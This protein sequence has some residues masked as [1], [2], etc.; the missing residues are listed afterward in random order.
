MGLSLLS[1]R[2]STDER[3]IFTVCLSAAAHKFLATVL[4]SEEHDDELTEHLQ[5]RLLH[6]KRA[7]LA[8]LNRIRLVTSPSLS[9]LQ[10]IL[11]GVGL[12]ICYLPTLTS[13]Q[14]DLAK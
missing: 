12:R 3:D 7:A 14:S 11:C 9:L 6:Y 2:V 8:A 1:N 5:Q 13:C 4:A 10:A